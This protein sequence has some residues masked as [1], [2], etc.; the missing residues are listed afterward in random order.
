LYE[1]LVIFCILLS[2][3]AKKLCSQLTTQPKRGSAT[4]ARWGG[5]LAAAAVFWGGS[6]AFR[7]GGG[8]DCVWDMRRLCGL[9]KSD[10]D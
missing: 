10:F 7:H 3:I 4:A 8:D 1:F 5:L 6:A 9:G 2:C